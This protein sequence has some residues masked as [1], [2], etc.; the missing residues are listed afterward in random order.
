M[1]P[2]KGE[3]DS[4]PSDDVTLKD[5]ILKLIQWWQYLLSRWKTIVLA[6]IIGGVL[7]IAYS[8]MTKPQYIATL[9]FALDDEKSGGS[10]GAAA[11]LASQFGFDLG[12]SGG[13]GAFSGDN[14][15]ELMKSRSMVEKTLLLPVVINN[16]QQTL[17]QFYISFTQFYEHKPELN[18]VS[19]LPNVDRAQFTLQQDSVLG[20]F[21]NGIVKAN[22]SVDKADKKLNIITVKV[23]SQ[24]ELFSK[25]FTEMLVKNVSDFYIETKTKKS[26]RNV[27]I[28][29]H[30]TDSVRVALNSAITGVASS[31]DINPNPNPALQ[32]IRV[33]SLRKQVD[34]QAN[35]AILTELVKNLELSKMSLRRETPLVQVIDKPILPLEK[36]KFGKIK[37]FVIFGFVLGFLTTLFLLMRKL[38]KDAL[39]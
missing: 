18:K 32:I 39:R 29:Q 4:A 26:A 36:K 38:L 27:A 19:F 15:L 10:L 11:G 30:Q 22:L 23:T 12:A 20:T 3:I 17:A 7:G 35:T 21:Y 34:V 5:V 8:A 24:N 6:A 25:Y 14:L 33:P 28:L 2:E 16:K 1:N 9:S 31:A 13:G 37:G